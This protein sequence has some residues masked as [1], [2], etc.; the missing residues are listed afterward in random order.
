MAPF[1]FVVSLVNMHTKGKLITF[2]GT[3]G[4]GKSTQITSLAKYLEQLGYTVVVLR[5]P[6]GTAIGESIREL[7]KDPLHLN[8]MSPE[9]ELF[10]FAAS[11]A[12]LVRQIIQPALNAGSIVLC[13]RFIDS[14]FVYQG[15]GR[16]LSHNLIQS[17]TQAATAGLRPDYTFILDVPAEIGLQRARR[18]TSHKKDRLEQESEAFYKAIQIGYRTLA[19]QQ[20]YRYGLIDGR[21]SIEIIEATIR[22][23][24]KNIIA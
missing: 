18:R 9:A 4:A 5:E 1:K 19:F 14:T 23:E 24:L 16:G 10:L 8:T 22:N 3:E 12:Q 13:D 21:D 2:E 11:R 17:V 7:L 20:P 15:I 6:G